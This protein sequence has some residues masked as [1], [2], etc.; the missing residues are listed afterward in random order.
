MAV[1]DTLVERLVDIAMHVLHHDASDTDHEVKW[2]KE[3]LC[4]E[5][6]R[7]LKESRNVKAKKRVGRRGHG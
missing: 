4:K 2:E 6:T 7:A 1:I 5:F 3:R